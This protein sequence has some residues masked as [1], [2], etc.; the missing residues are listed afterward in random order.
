[1]PST[2]GFFCVS[3]ENYT[4]RGLYAENA[5]HFLSQNYE[6]HSNVRILEDAISFARLAENCPFETETQARRLLLSETLLTMRYHH[7]QNSNNLRKAIAKLDEAE[8]KGIN[9]SETGRAKIFVSNAR[10]H[11]ALA[12]EVGSADFEQFISYEEA[13]TGDS[14]QSIYDFAE[15]SFHLWELM[16][17]G[18]CQPPKEIIDKAEESIKRMLSSKISR[19]NPAYHAIT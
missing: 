16:R 3:S 14:I 18:G 10:Y 9:D 1:M 4:S 11:L 17:E 6:Y 2:L 12:A 8:M 7:S 19:A 15:Y 5:C 13:M